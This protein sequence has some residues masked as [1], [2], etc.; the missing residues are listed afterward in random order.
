MKI[1]IIAAMAEELSLLKNSLEDVTTNTIGQFKYHTG[2][3]DGVEVIL[4]QS[5]I[6]KVNA[7]VGATL[8]LDKFNPDC[9]LNTGV[10]GGLPEHINIG[11]VV[12]SSEVR[13][14]DADATAFNYEPGQ[15]PQ[16]PPAFSTDALLSR[17]AYKAGRSC[18]EISV[19]HGPILSGDSFIHN[20]SQVSFIESTFPDAMA[21]EMEGAAVAQTTFLFNVPFLLIRSISDKI[22]EQNNEKTYSQCIEKA[23]ANST[24]IVLTIIQDLRKE[25]WTQ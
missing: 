4:F 5:G 23:A 14:Y 24:K 1:G 10:A 8:L 9:V 19:H 7:A 17:L 18:E 12:I 11:D 20:S 2:V 3:L 21:V 15:I 25:Q 6:G 13:H 16:M 22:A